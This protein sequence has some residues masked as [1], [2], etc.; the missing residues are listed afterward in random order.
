[1]KKE[2]GEEFWRLHI[3]FNIGAVLIDGV[4]GGGAEAVGGS[5]MGK[6]ANITGRSV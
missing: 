1:M 5:R 2:D 4:I 6:S 3:N